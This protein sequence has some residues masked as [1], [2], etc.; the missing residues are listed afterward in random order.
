MDGNETNKPLRYGWTTGACACAAAKA[1]CTALLTGDF[2]DPVQIRLPR[3]QTPHFALEMREAGNGWAR[4]GIIK[5][6]GD[7]PDVTHGALIISRVSFA[8]SG[9]GVCFKAGE[10]VGHVSLPGLTLAVGEPAINPVPRRM[11]ATALQE[12]AAQHGAACDFEVEISIPGGEKIARKTLNARLGILDGLSILGTTGIVTPYSCSAWIHS[13][14][15]GVDVAR[16]AG[17]QVLAACVGSTSE[18]AVKTLYDL[19]DTG[20]VEMGNFVGGVL[21]YTRANPLPKLVIAGG[22]GKICKLAQGEMDL[23]SRR[24]RVDFEALA[25]LLESLGADEHSVLRARRANTAL[26]VLQI[27]QEG[28]FEIAALVAAEA[29]KV[30]LGKLRGVDMALEVV[31]SDRSGAVIGR[32]P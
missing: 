30:C 14:H 9:A 18:K 29:R 15:S 10:G 16:A 7:D 3:G 26:E 20:L 22:F 24:C 23:H 6:A 2:P 1:A 28:G 4:A 19:P 5:D 25:R 27:A 32:A 17:L 8:Q 21:K 11:I 13:I 12:V 31:V